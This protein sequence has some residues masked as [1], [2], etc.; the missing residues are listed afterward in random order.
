MTITVTTEDIEKGDPGKLL[1]MPRC[2]SDSAR[3][4]L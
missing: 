3:D 1:H 4:R 2:A